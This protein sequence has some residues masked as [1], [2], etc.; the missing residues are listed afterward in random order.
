V[1]GA[2]SKNGTH[3]NGVDKENGSGLNGTQ[4]ESKQTD[5][6]YK[7][8]TK[9][10]VTICTPPDLKLLTPYVLLEQ[11]EWYENELNFIRDYLKPGMNV[12]DI[13]AGFGVYALPAAKLVG[14]EGAVFAFEPGEVAKHHLEMSKLENGFQNLEVIGK[15]VTDKSGKLAFSSEE[16]PE[17]N[18]LS[19]GGELTVSAITADAWWQFEGEPRIDLIKLDINGDE[20]EALVGAETILEKSSPVVLFSI[21]EAGQ[22]GQKLNQLLSVYGYKLY[23]YIPG[24]GLLAEHDS[25]AGVDHYMQNL[26]AVK[27][28]REAEL[29]KLGWFH[30]ESVAPDEPAADLWKTELA[31]LPWT[32][33]LMDNWES[34]SDSEGILNYL[35]ALNYLI[36]AEQIDIQNSEDI[37][38]RSQK[39]VLLLGAAQILINLY[40]QGA[41]STSVVFTLV[42]TL[43]ALG[44]RGQAVEVMQKLLETTKLG[45]QNMNTD[46]PFLLPLAEQ[47]QSNIKTEFNNWLTVRTVEAWILL[48]DLTTYLSGEQEKKMMEVLEGNPEVGKWTDRISLINTAQNEGTITTEQL[49]KFSSLVYPS[50]ISNEKRY[51]KIDD[52]IKIDQT[53]S[54]LLN[55]LWSASHSKEKA[56]ILVNLADRLNESEF[57]E[58]H[59]KIVKEAQERL[60]HDS[61]D[62]MAFFL[63]VKTLLAE[64]KAPEKSEDLLMQRLFKSGWEE[65]AALYTYFFNYAEI[66]CEVDEPKLSVIVVSN[67][68]NQ[69]VIENLKEIDRQRKPDTELIFVNNGLDSEKLGAVRNH[70]DMIVHLNQNSG[71]CMAR[72]FGAMFAGSSLF[73]FIDDDG[74]PEQ[75]MLKAHQVI[76]KERNVYVAR[77]VYRPKKEGGFMPDHYDLGPETRPAVCFLEGNT[78][79]QSVPFFDVGGW[80]DSILV[81]HEGLELSYRYYQKGY[82][83]EKL[84]YFPEAVLKHDY[85]KN[86]SGQNRK[87][88]LLKISKLLIE[89]IYENIF[90]SINSWPTSFSQK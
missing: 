19:D 17:L 68:V 27:S 79:F 74:M 87:N 39:A 65:K 44:K 45:Q 51:G 9:D 61:S 78:S 37:Q 52:E 90:D 40:N 85:V 67:K 10:D 20:A 77:G 58:H 70:A 55:K 4:K 75:G 86:Q 53:E 54:D 62:G 49:G 42:R 1:N 24:P 21:G 41:N 29:E 48:K 64:K 16:T 57:S 83:Q 84:I 30:D 25:Q 60:S 80:N 76:H 47:D 88:K 82:D 31:Q 26:I 50:P 13:G 5:E 35:K 81:Y 89:N 15:A 73:M 28:D 59:K 3:T 8:E 43:N 34:H 2:L 72:N 7:I 23:E 38:A 63:L 6:P 12:L 33:D 14:K 71:A 32:A 69:D 46:L 18:R 66:L 22:N 11:E 56:R 36:A